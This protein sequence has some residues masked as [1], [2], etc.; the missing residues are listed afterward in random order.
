MFSLSLFSML[1]SKWDGHNISSQDKYVSW[2]NVFFLHVAERNEFWDTLV[3]LEM[4]HI[5]YTYIIECKYN[6]S[7]TYYIFKF[8][9]SKC[10]T[11][12]IT[13]EGPKDHFFGQ[14]THFFTLACKISI[15]YT[16][17]SHGLHLRCLLSLISLWP[18][19]WSL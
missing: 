14:H 8:K 7:E 3:S 18:Y 9:C 16:R 10:D 15:L 2:L 19:C 5:Y 11:S 12:M 4:Y 6:R 13:Q 17:S 1:N